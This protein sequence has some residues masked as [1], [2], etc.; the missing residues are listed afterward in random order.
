MTS[1]VLVDL[2]ILIEMIIGLI[3]TY[4]DNKTISQKKIAQHNN[5]LVHFLQIKDQK[6]KF[7]INQIINNKYVIMESVKF[8]SAIMV[9]V[10]E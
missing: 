8:K 10:K 5:F 4:R 2:I 6:E 1:L 3:K 7:I 9:H